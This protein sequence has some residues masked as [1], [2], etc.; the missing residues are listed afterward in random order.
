MKRYAPAILLCLGVC[1]SIAGCGSPPPP[2]PQ[3]SKDAAN[4][5]AAQWTPEMKEKFK[6]AMKGHE[7]TAGDATK[8]VSVKK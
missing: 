1:L 6:D 8:G 5:A 2:E 3:E 4:A 7:K